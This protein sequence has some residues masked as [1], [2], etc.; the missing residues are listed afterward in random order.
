MNHRTLSAMVN[1]G[2]GISPDPRR[3]MAHMPV[4][5]AL[6]HAYLGFSPSTSSYMPMSLGVSPSNFTPPSS[7]FQHSPGSPSTGSPRGFGPT[8][9]ARGGALGKA[10]ALGQYSKRMGW[11]S[12]GSGTNPTSGNRTAGADSPTF[13]HGGHQNSPSGN[14]ESLS[15]PHAESPVQ[16]S[17]LASPRGSSY[18]ASQFKPRSSNQ[19]SK[20]A[21]FLPASAVVMPKIQPALVG[22]GDTSPPSTSGD[23]NPEYRYDRHPHFSRCFGVRNT[24]LVV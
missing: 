15:S 20:H 18:H 2:F 23:F 5:H 14:V 1:P 17:Q 11:G 10:A 12:P 21:N 3:R 13:W 7:H 4:N 8:S 16:S 22:G 24:M 6:G 9:P 19:A